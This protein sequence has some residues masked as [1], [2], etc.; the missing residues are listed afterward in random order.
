[1]L[2]TTA[3]ATVASAVHHLSQIG[4]LRRQLGLPQSFSVASGFVSY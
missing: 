4:P 1:M 3:T 2:S